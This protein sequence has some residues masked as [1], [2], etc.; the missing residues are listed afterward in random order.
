M[1]KL[2]IQSKTSFWSLSAEHP[3]F[4]CYLKFLKKMVQL[5]ADPS[6]L[7]T[8]DP[9]NAS[10]SSWITFLTPPLLSYPPSSRSPLTSSKS[11]RTW[12][13]YYLLVT[14]DV[15]SLYTNIDHFSGLEA[16]RDMID[17]VFGCLWHEVH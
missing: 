14:L 6:F 5:K 16:D 11:W 1:E 12:G 7:T 2:T 8:M 13:L 15:T 3:N 9:L 4:S 10:H 17:P